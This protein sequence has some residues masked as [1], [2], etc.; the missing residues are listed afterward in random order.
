MKNNKVSIA[1]KPLVYSAFRHI[2][3]KV[4][5]A[6]GEYVDNSIQSFD[7]NRKILSKI[8]PDGKLKVDI[9]ISEDKIVITDNAFGIPENKYEKAFELANL[10]LDNSGLNEFGMGMKVS[11]IWLSNVWEVE[12]KAY[13]ENLR[14]IMKFDVNE[15]VEKQETLLPITEKLA[16][17][18]EHY[19]KITLTELSPNAPKKGQMHT[20][21]KHLESIYSMYI[22]KGILILTINGEVL[23]YTPLEV[24]NAPYYKEKDGKPIKWKFPIKFVAGKYSV[25]GY[26]GLLNKMSTSVDNGFLLF[27]RGRVI[28]TSYDD[29]YR[30]EILC[31]QVGSPL[32]KRLFGELHLEGF[33]VS[34]TK[35][36]FQEDDDLE[37]FIEM[38]KDKLDKDLS[39]NIFAQG[40]HYRLPVSKEER[41]KRDKKVLSILK[42][43]FD[44]TRE[45]P[46][47]VPLPSIKNTEVDEKDE[48]AEYNNKVEVKD[49]LVAK[50]KDGYRTTAVLTNGK[51]VELFISETKENIGL[52]S[53]RQNEDKKEGKVDYLI[54]FNSESNVFE[55]FEKALSTDEGLELLVYFI[56]VLVST[57]LSLLDGGNDFEYAIYFRNTFN[58]LFGAL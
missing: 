51:K 23:K 12:T 27:R 50:Q 24:L 30:P 31:G 55:R 42:G 1:T 5:C 14:K 18:N 29:R 54:E 6:L 2:N 11:S 45:K 40:Q 47:P 7:D 37:A 41:K 46:I 43:G 13:G 52:Y 53:I 33:S 15:V 32:Y 22:L 34:F 35:N 3:N 57:E 16:P 9:M 58:S 10:P 25:N 44:N 26:I 56:K 49:V 17:A 48:S 19:T 8:N 38:L 4:W 21:K 36:S 39:Y 20:I 28:G